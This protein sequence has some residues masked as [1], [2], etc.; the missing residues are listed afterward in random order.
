[1]I[2]ANF[3]AVVRMIAENCADMVLGKAPPKPMTT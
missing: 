3:N 1:M 2:S